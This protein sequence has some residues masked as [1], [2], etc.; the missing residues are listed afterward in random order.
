[1]WKESSCNLESEDTNKRFC[2][3]ESGEGI[4]IPLYCHIKV[5]WKRVVCYQNARPP[6]AGIKKIK[7]SSKTCASAYLYCAESE[8]FLGFQTISQ[9]I[10]PSERKIRMGRR[11]MKEEHFSRLAFSSLQKFNDLKTQIQQSARLR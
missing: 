3:V 2:V 5:A 11:C 7:F 8:N 4:L 10:I 6:P 9:L 1:M